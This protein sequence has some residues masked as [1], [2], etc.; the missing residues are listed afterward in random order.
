MSRFFVWTRL[1]LLLASGGAVERGEDLSGDDWDGSLRFGVCAVVILDGDTQ[2]EVAVSGNQEDM[3]E[4]SGGVAGDVEC[5]AIVSL[6]DA[7]LG[8]QERSLKIPSHCNSGV[9]KALASPALL[10]IMGPKAKS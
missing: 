4:E 3:C 10:H 2:K 7:F 8:R 1:L 5:I 6:L 9:G